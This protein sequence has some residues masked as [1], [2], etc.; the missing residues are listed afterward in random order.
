MG[1]SVVSVCDVM[2]N[3]VNFKMDLSRLELGGMA[4][5]I[6]LTI[7]HYNDNPIREMLKYFNISLIQ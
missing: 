5:Y 4:I 3:I 7:Y 6:L 2:N 1:V